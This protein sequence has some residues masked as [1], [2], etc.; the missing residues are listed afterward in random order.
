MAAGSRSWSSGSHLLLEMDNVHTH[1]GVSDSALAQETRP[2]ALQRAPKA[3]LS[4]NWLT[5]PQISSKTPHL[6]FPSFPEGVRITRLGNFKSPLVI[7]DLE[8]FTTQQLLPHGVG[9]LTKELILTAPCQ[10]CWIWIPSEEEKCNFGFS[11]K[12]S[13]HRSVSEAKAWLIW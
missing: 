2:K 6:K 7:K 1:P 13:V 8:S 5:D 12:W 11:W 4:F 3:W 9:E 10:S